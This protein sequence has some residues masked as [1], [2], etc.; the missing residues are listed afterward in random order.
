MYE[1]SEQ[2]GGTRP[3]PINFKNGWKLRL[4][5]YRTIYKHCTLVDKI[6]SYGVRVDNF[7]TTI[8][9]VYWNETIK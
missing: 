6:V 2:S 4:K 3:L 7:E 1:T 5:S 8:P 9:D